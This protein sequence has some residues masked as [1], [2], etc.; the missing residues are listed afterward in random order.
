MN[1]LNRACHAFLLLR[2]SP[3]VSI[4]SGN[5]Q[6]KSSAPRLHSQRGR[7]ALH[8]SQFAADFLQESTIKSMEITDFASG[9]LYVRYPG[10]M[11]WEYEKPDRQVI[12]TDARSCGS[13]G[14]WTTR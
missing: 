8:G 11:R 3:P 5:G 14:R 10:M 13:T 1:R 12:I 2:S 4:L 6:R 7:K 9:R